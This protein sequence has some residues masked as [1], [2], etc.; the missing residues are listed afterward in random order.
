MEK[1][2]T[3]SLVR[4]GISPFKITRGRIMTTGNMTT[5]RHNKRL[6]ILPVVIISGAYCIYNV[7]PVMNFYI[8]KKM[9]RTNF[10]FN[11][12]NTSE[13]EIFLLCFINFCYVE[14]FL[15]CFFLLI[16]F[17]RTNTIITDN[18]NLIRKHLD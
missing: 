11:M 10:F 12:H 8:N 4:F 13:I 16:N 17:T 3:V 15:F 6:V 7:N 14:S 5:R 9:L 18:C 2:R 1:F